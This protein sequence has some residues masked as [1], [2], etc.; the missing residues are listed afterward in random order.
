MD[1]SERPSHAFRRH[2]WEVVRLAF[3]RALVRDAGFDG[4]PVTILDVGAGDG[5]LATRL[6][7]DMPVGSALTCWDASYTSDDIAALAAAASAGGRVAFSADW[8]AARFDLLLLLDVLEHVERDREFLARLVADCLGP[9]GSAVVSVPA[10]TWLYGAHD[11][12]LNHHRRYA[13]RQALDLLTGAGLRVVRCGGLFHSLLLPRALHKVREVLLGGRQ[14]AGGT[15]LEWTHGEGL[16]RLVE[17][18]LGTEARLSLVASRAGVSVPGLSW[19]ALCR[20]R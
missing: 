18:V 12:Q 7:A 6:L 2:P 20:R 4:R 16:A 8:P 15:A 1:L 10:W 9:A 17:T 19:W 14:A 11:A 13:P 5:W 3:F